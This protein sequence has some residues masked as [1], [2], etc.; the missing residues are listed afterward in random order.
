MPEVGVLPPS[1]PVVPFGTMFCDPPTV[2][3]V[4]GG[5]VVTIVAAEAALLQPLAVTMTV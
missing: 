3:V 4:G 2:A 1:G 5:V